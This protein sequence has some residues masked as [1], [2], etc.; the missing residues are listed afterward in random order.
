MKGIIFVTLI[1]M[2]FVVGAALDGFAQSAYDG[3]YQS[4][5]AEVKKVEIQV[6][7]LEERLQKIEQRFDTVI[8]NQEKILDELYKVIVRVRRG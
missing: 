1:A 4:I 8:E 6:K 2:I 5:G 7:V 3:D